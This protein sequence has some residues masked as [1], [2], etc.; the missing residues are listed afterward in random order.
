MVAAIL[1]AFGFVILIDVAIIAITQPDV[2]YDGFRQVLFVII[3]GLLV[4]GGA[5]TFSWPKRGSVETKE[6]DEPP[7]SH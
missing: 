7:R 3:G 6:E 5:V 2:N 4:V 1:G